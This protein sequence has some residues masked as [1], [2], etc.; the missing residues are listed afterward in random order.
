MSNKLRLCFLTLFF[1]G[2]SPKA[3]G[4]VGSFVALLLA[5]PILYFSNNTLFLCAILIGAIAIK[6]I[7]I[8]EANGG[9]HDDKS[10]V[11][12]ELVGLWIALSFVP[13]SWVGIIAAFVFFRIFDIWKPSLVGYFDSKVQGGWG[14]VGDDAIAGILAGLLSAG[15]VRFS[16]IIW[17]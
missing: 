12:D 13:F 17:G 16:G 2:K 11:I 15:L 9:E 4:T 14:V 3:S 6:Q 7:D 5:L 1:S 8:F 10:I